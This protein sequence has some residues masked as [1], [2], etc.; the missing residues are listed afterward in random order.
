MSTQARQHELAPRVEGLLRARIGDVGLQRRY[1]RVPDADVAPRAQLLA[2]VE[3]FTA[4]DDEVEF[5]GL[6]RERRTRRDRA[7]RRLR[8]HR[9]GIRVGKRVAWCPPL[10]L[11]R[12]AFGEQGWSLEQ[13]SP[14]TP[15]D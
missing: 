7:R 5:V 15:T 2:R 10:F 4:L 11:L 1:H 9:R 3:H 13:R 8:R 6:A 12:L 14:I